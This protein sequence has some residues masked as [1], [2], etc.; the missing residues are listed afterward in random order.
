MNDIFQ[1]GLQTH[2]QLAN[3]L[4]NQ[5]GVLQEIAATLIDAIKNKHRVYIL[6]NGGSAAD[7]QH[8]A[9]ELIG[10]FKHNRPPLPAMALTTD[11]SGLLS[12]GNDYGFGYVF[13]R[14][15]ETLVWPGDI[16]WALSTS[17]NSSNVIEAVHM[18]R[19][20]QAIVVGFTGRSG[21]KL[22]PLCEHC[23]CI[24]ETDSARIQELHQVAYHLICEAVE[25][26]FVEHQPPNPELENY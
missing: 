23:L 15:V 6:G 25:Q 10:R 20:R 24:D 12:I 16:L 8:I 9:A 11:T 7:A 13:T 2:I 21:G 19:S 18:A 17:G 26:H 22:K 4:N 3:Q 14:Q 1:T 5:L